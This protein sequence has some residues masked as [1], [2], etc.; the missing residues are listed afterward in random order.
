MT[1]EYILY[2]IIYI[3]CGYIA[4]LKDIRKQM[5]EMLESKYYGNNNEYNYQYESSVK[6]LFNQGSITM[7]LYFT[8]F[9]IGLLILNILDKSINFIL[10]SIK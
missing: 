5:K 6:R 7:L 4:Y 2:A 8:V 3:L 9:W 10:K 1:K